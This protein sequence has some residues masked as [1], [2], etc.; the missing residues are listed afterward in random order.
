MKNKKENFYIWI[1]LLIIIVG[2]FNINL[3]FGNGT[4]FYFLLPIYLRILKSVQQSL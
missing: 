1:F 3:F 2:D 4:C